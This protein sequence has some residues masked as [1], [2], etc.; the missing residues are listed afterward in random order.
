MNIGIIGLQKSGK[1]TIFNALTGQGAEVSEYASQRVE[2]NLAVV[3]VQDQRVASLSAMYQPRKTIYASVEFVDFAGLSAGAA[4]H[5]VFSGAAMQLVKNADALCAVVRNFHDQVIDETHGAPDP[6]GAVETIA[7]ELI[8][9]DQIIAERRLE[10]IAHD[11]QRGKK[12]PQLSAEQKLIE[13]LIAHLGE[14]HPLRSLEL[15]VDDRKTIA[16]FQFL[17]VKPV[18]VVLNSSED[19]YGKS[20]AVMDAI[21]QHYPVVEFAGSFEM[22]LSRLEDDGERQ[23]FML[24]MGIA[25]SAR[26]RLTTF[27][28]RTLGY[29]SFFTVGKDEVRA[30]TIRDGQTAVEAAGTVHSDLAR[31]FIRAEVFSYDD[32]MQYGSEKAV[33]DAGRFRVEGKHYVVADGD[34]INVRF[35]V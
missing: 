8:L 17:S 34:I 30:W 20:D 2:P 9:A 26:T 3:E 29:V 15:S 32:L 11:L 1:T 22:E 18:F 14:E 31:G 4:E 13:R 33:R 19:S 25:E 28:Y 27:A 10:R 16:G 7:A 23:V 6:A 5:G 24:D 35:S 21:G 12:T